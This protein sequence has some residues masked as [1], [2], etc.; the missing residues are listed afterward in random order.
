MYNYMYVETCT[1]KEFR[2]FFYQTNKF[3]Q[4][5]ILVIKSA[6]MKDKKKKIWYVMSEVSVNR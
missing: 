4:F 3:Y 5:E 6:E 1:N 2:F